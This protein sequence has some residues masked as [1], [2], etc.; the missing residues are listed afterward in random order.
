MVA[1]AR[2]KIKH[3]E[4]IVGENRAWFKEFRKI[5][6]GVMNISA[7]IQIVGMMRGV[8]SRSMVHIREASYVMKLGVKSINLNRDK[9]IS[10]VGVECHSLSFARRAR[11]IGKISFSI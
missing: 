9:V 7:V 5:E 10:L 4:R 11:R 3:R 1:K 2:I 6:E 8:V